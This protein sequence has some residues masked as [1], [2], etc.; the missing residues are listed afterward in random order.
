MENWTAQSRPAPQFEQQQV[1][2]APSVAEPEPPDL[3]FMAQYLDQMKIEAIVDA[4]RTRFGI[5]GLFAFFAAAPVAYLVEHVIVFQGRSFDVLADAQA[6]VSPERVAIA[7]AVGLAVAIIVAIVS[8]LA[9]QRVTRAVKAYEA[10]LIA[11]GG[12]PLPERGVP[13]EERRKDKNSRRA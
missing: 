3:D 12:T 5:N 1:V 7:L 13:L 4:E 6:I 9:R 8:H 10:R 2:I 11:L